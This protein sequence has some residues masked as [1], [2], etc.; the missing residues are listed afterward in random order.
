M[1]RSV[2]SPAATRKPLA[3]RLRAPCGAVTPGGRAMATSTTTASAPP[4]SRGVVR[5]LVG[6]APIDAGVVPGTS[7]I[8]DTSSVAITSGVSGAVG[9]GVLVASGEAVG[10]AVPVETKGANSSDG[11]WV[12]VTEQPA[13]G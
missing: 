6:S 4:F 7:M 1:A 10:D 11:D 3:V 8:A 13:L 2:P 5:G 9:G 12:S